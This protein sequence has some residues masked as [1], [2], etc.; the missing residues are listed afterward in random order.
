[1][2]NQT[3]IWDFLSLAYLKQNHINTFSLSS[4]DGAQQMFTVYE[5]L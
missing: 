5:Q 1:M 2:S 3:L 4:L